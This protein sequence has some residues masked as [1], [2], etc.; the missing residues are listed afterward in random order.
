[1]TDWVSKFMGPFLDDHA[2]GIEELTAM[3]RKR[4]TEAAKLKRFIHDNADLVHATDFP[5]M[6]E[7]IVIALI[8]R[9]I[10]DKIFQR[11]LYGSIPHYVEVLT[12]VENSLQT[13]V[14]PKRGKLIISRQ[15]PSLAF[16]L[17]SKQTYSRCET[18]RPKPTTQSC[19]PHSSAA[20][21]RSAPGR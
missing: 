15:R 6:D 12:F 19:R 14:D 21:V 11:I 2:E 3:A 9:F 18:G 17:T 10:H 5:E 20:C 13:H 1:V 16:G 7:D 8:L 4:P